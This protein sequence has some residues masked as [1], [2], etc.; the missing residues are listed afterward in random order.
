ML[1]VTEDKILLKNKKFNKQKK[2]HYFL[3]YKKSFK[4]KAQPACFLSL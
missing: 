4:I 1:N 3:K 2:N